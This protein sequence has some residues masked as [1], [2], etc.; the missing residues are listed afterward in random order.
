MVEIML[1]I[2]VIYKRNH[3]AAESGIQL[4]EFLQRIAY[5]VTG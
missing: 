2:Y 4:I 5:Q 3:L 1:S